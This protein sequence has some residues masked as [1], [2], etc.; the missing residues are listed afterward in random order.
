MPNRPL[1][2][3]SRRRLVGVAILLLASG[4]AGPGA[5]GAAR[6]DRAD[7]VRAGRPLIDVSS[8][9]APQSVSDC[10]VAGVR[11]MKI[12]DDYVAVRA[13]PGGGGM[14]MLKNPA[15]RRTGLTVDIAS[16]GAGS[17]VRLYENGMVVSGQWRSLVKRCAG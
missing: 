8:P 3:P 16:R 12:P 2:A 15:T 10:V 17:Q 11:A 14:V 1:P 4:C 6:G 7:P 9:R 5:T 13:L